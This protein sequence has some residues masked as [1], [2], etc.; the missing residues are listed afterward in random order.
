MP[1]TE[2]LR[3]CPNAFVAPVPRKACLSKSRAILQVLETLSPAVAP[4]S[5]DEFYLDFTGTE[6]MPHGE[7]LEITAR[8]IQERVLEETR[9]Q[10]SIGGAT[11]RTIAKMA[12]GR[13]KPAGVHVVAPGEEAAFI[14][15]LS[16]AEI[17]GIGPVFT[18]ELARHGLVSVED[19]LRVG[20]EWLVRWLGEGRGTWL[21]RIIRGIDTHAVVARESRRSLSSE[22]TF[23]RNLVE[24]EVVER[25]LLRLSRSVATSIRSE[26]LRARTVTVKLRDPDFTTRRAS[27]SLREP[28]ESDVAV[29]VVARTLLRDLRTHRRLP[30]RLLG[31]ALSRFVD[32]DQAMQLALFEEGGVESERDR[33]LARA[34]DEVRAKLGGEGLMPAR[35]IEWRTREEWENFKGTSSPTM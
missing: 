5:I 30:V 21:A 23:G 35:L 19:A 14:R 22:N 31:V 32:R 27:R 25:E 8:R 28:V 11:S 20:D 12:A 6:R 33:K 15:G 29:F 1:T 9:I 10:V 18:A 26:G 16:L 17:P 13:A 4:A 24:D 34:S 2:A 3:L 7:A